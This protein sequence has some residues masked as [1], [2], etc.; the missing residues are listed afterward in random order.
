MAD[1]ITVPIIKLINIRKT[2]D[3]SQKENNNEDIVEQLVNLKYE[4][5][6]LTRDI[7]KHF[8]DKFYFLFKDTTKI[9]HKQ[10]KNTL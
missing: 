1:F 7:V 2:M 9:T 8:I 3:S 6:H 10:F 4:G 5:D